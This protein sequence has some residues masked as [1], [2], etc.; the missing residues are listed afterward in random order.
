MDRQLEHLK[1]LSGLPNVHIQVMPFSV[2]VYAALRAPF[3]ILEFGDAADSDLLYL[4][5]PEGQVIVREEELKTAQYVDLFREMEKI[6]TPPENFAESVD[7]LLRR[8]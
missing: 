3:V 6:A 5:N 8:S 4:E 1:T 7:K 2:G